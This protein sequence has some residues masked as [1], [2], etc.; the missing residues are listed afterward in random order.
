MLYFVLHKQPFVLL[1]Q[2]LLSLYCS[3][4]P[5]KQ[6]GV[7]KSVTA[8]MCV[9]AAA[10][11]K[12]CCAS[13]EISTSLCKSYFCECRPSCARGCAMAL[14]DFAHINFL[15]SIFRQ[16]RPSGACGC[17]SQKSCQVVLYLLPHSSFLLV[18]Q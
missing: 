16:T 2:P 9:R 6:R 5:C 17:L 11:F 12:D 10:S 7:H 14:D 8:V 4:R 1:K 3:S 18:Q 15:V 13:K